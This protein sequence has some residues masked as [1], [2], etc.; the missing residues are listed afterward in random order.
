[1]TDNN[2]LFIPSA[3]RLEE[4]FGKTDYDQIE[5]IHEENENFYLGH[6]I[7]ILNDNKHRK[8]YMEHY[9]QFKHLLP[10]GKQ[11]FNAV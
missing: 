2:N 6:D 4:V 7:Q 3:L 9:E 5:K 10:T 8:K 11:I 1:M